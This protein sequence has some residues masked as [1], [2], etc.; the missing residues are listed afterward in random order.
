MTDRERHHLHGPVSTLCLEW[1]SINPE[2]NDWEPAKQGPTFT[3]DRDGRQEGRV[4]DKEAT[5]TTF[6]AQGLRTTVS[7]LGPRIPRQRGLEYG[8]CMDANVKCDV[9]ARYD[10]NDRPVE[11]VYRNS[12][13]K[14]LHRT[15]LEYDERNRLV[16][17]RV[18]YGEAFD[19]TWCS[20]EESSGPVVPS[21]EHIEQRIPV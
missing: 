15:L 3:F 16:R 12:E 9:L 8:I 7:P 13:Q 21:P 19:G 1:A 5:I 2:T 17:E 18:L 20:A 11:V 4:R 6:D 10:R 14:P